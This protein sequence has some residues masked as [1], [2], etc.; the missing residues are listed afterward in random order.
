[1]ATAPAAKRY[2]LETVAVHAGEG[3]ADERICGAATLPVF[4]S[5][6][7]VRD[8]NVYDGDVSRGYADV[9]YAR[10]NN[11]PNH[12]A[13]AKKLSELEGTEAAVVTGSGMAAISTSLLTVLRS[14]DH[15]ITQRSLY[16]GT[17]HFITKDL[18]LLGIKHTKVFYVESISN[19]L[20]EIPDLVAVV[21]FAR[22]HN[23]VTII[24][25]TFASPVIFRPADWGF[26][27]V[28]H[29]AT[30]YLNGHS[31]LICGVVCSSAE[32]IRQVTDKLNHLGGCLDPHGCFL[33]Q[34]GL[35][36]LPLR[37]RQQNATALALAQ[38]LQSQPQVSR[39]YYPGLISDSSNARV[40]QLFGGSCGG[41]VSFELIGGAV[42]ANK[43]LQEL[44]LCLVAPSLGGVET[45]ITRP[46]TTT[47]VGFTKEECEA[48]GVTEGLIRVAVG[49]ES[50]ADIIEDFQLALASLAQMG[51]RLQDGKATEFGV[52]TSILTKSG[53]SL[54][55]SLADEMATSMAM[56]TNQVPTAV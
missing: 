25:S 33:L 45:L 20:L 52:R 39:V 17:D 41:V 24:D 4:Q 11:T 46:I 29:S 37:V 6:T 19:P 43:L 42:A 26:D 49:I 13:L 10:C 23:L 36:T 56:P 21:A 8:K 47:H 15:M 28:V 14:G 53:L 18:P 30:K 34:R 9:K 27:I 32:R 31:D 40:Q 48:S 35:K 50:T 7:Y 16:G 5:S 38:F 3:S 44:K 22:E 55:K 54:V 1:M 2:G 51:N 12:F